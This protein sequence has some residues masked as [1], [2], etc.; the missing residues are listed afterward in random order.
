MAKRVK[1]KLE[2]ACMKAGLIDPGVRRKVVERV[3]G[4]VAATAGSGSEAGLGKILAETERMAAAEEEMKYLLGVTSREAIVPA[5]EGV[6]EK[7]KTLKSAAGLDSP[8]A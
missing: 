2:E 3:L 7:L 6:I 8:P 1:E 4:L 5:L